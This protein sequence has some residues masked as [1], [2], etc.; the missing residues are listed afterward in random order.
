MKF[1]P[2][3]VIPLMLGAACQSL[4]DP[5][6]DSSSDIEKLDQQRAQMLNQHYDLLAPREF[7]KFDENLQEAKDKNQDKKDAVVEVQRSQEYAK[8]ADEKS[9][10]TLAALET[11]MTSRQAAIDAG[12]GEYK[13]FKEIDEDLQDATKAAAKGN[14]KP[15]EKERD[16]LDNRYRNIE[17][18][19]IVARQIG[20]MKAK[21]ADLKSNDADDYAPNTFKR[22][23]QNLVNA[24]QAIRA[25]R[26]NSS[27][28]N[29]S[30]ILAN[31][32]VNRLATISENARRLGNE[33][34]AIEL[35]DK[36][37]QIAEEK[38]RQDELTAQV[39]AAKAQKAKRAKT[40]RRSAPS[41]AQ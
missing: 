5:H 37:Q 39:A 28:L 40:T 4:N 3:L 35:W 2:F 29:Q 41:K 19:A 10:V 30:Q 22:T 24:E 33:R 34:S 26:Y 16:A 13:Q 32:E 8:E 21:L 31:Q 14:L 23:E 17:A 7:R 15:V 12:A 20:D 25:N 1:L 9:K 6:V 11:V 27:V 38:K 36:D 18:D